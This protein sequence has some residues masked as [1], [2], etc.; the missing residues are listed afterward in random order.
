MQRSARRQSLDVLSGAT[1]ALSL[2]ERAR[3]AHSSSKI[4]TGIGTGSV[5]QGSISARAKATRANSHAPSRKR[6]VEACESVPGELRNEEG[7]VRRSL[8]AFPAAIK[9]EIGRSMPPAGNSPS[10]RQHAS[11]TS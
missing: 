9:E 3:R 8:P 10:I 5:T 4:S 2:A 1:N 11:W 6:D 7:S